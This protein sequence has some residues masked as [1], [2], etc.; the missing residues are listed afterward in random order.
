MRIYLKFLSKQLYAA[1]K[2]SCE[3]G[4]SPRRQSIASDRTDSFVTT[5]FENENGNTMAP[6]SLL[7]QL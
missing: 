3:K 2:N 5:L 6:L 4:A 7:S 1:T